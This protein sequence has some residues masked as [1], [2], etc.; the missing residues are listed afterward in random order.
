MQRTIDTSKLYASWPQ[1]ARSDIVTIEHA[2]EQGDFK[3]MASCAEKNAM[4]MHATMMSAWPPLVYWLPE[5]LAM[6]QHVWRLRDSGVD[7]YFTMDA[8]PNLKLL[9]LSENQSLLE[10]EFPIMDVIK[11]FAE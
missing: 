9:F 7:V 4:S 3:A 5:S 2:I 10:T 11:P 1:Q 6:M 8:G